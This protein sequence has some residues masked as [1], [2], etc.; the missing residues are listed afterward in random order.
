MHWYGRDLT[1]FLYMNSTYHSLIHCIRQ[2]RV[3]FDLRR[4]AELI[5]LSKSGE[6]NPTAP[7]IAANVDMIEFIVEAAK[8]NYQ[9]A[10]LWFQQQLLR[11]G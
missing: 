7:K 1:A 10:T 2:L 5:M 9:F 6:R 11:N 4:L 3:L 8:F